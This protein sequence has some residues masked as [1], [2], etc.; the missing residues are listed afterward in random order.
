MTEYNEHTKRKS[1]EL[2][3]YQPEE[4]RR[5][6]T[7]GNPHIHHRKELFSTHVTHRS[8]FFNALSPA[9]AHFSDQYGCAFHQSVDE[10][11]ADGVIC[12]TWE[13]FFLIMYEIRAVSNPRLQ[14]DNL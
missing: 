12:V 6:P 14:R 8:R 13:S 4:S 3:R 1:M 7:Y 2:G 11:A 10:M 5:N 9:N